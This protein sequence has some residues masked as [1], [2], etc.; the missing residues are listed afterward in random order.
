MTKEAIL[1]TL[2]DYAEAYYAKGIDALM[3]VFDDSDNISIIGTGADEF[4][5][6]RAAVV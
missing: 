2:E 1:S 4:C 6:G 3:P 5:V